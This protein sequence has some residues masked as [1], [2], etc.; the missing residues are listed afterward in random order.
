[1]SVKDGGVLQSRAGHDALGLVACTYELDTAFALERSK[2]IVEGV[3][4]VD[5]LESIVVNRCD[6]TRRVRTPL[7]AIKKVGDQ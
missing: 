5:A 1:M 4:P 7:V 3:A 6:Q 2:F